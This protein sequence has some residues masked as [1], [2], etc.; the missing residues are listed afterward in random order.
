MSNDFYGDSTRWFIGRV[1]DNV[2]PDKRGRLQIRVYGLH[3]DNQID[4]PNAILPWAETLLP[5]TEGGASGIGKIPQIQ[6]SAMVFG[7]F[8][9]GTTSQSPLILGSLNQNESP[10]STQ[11]IQAGSRGDGAYYTSQSIGSNGTITTP[12]IRSKYQGGNANIDQRRV[13]CMNFFADNGFNPIIAAGIVGNLE[14]E[15]SNFDPT[16]VSGSRGEK[17]QGLAQWN[18]AVG[19]LQQLQRFAARQNKDYLDFFTQLEYI[20]HQLRGKSI[21]NDGGGD[22]SSLYSKLQKCTTFEGGVSDVNS[23]W[24]F[25]K[26]YEVPEDMRTELITREKHARKAYEQWSTTVAS[27]QATSGPQ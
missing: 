26:I 6:P 21:N 17:S 12:D 2:D 24:L 19:R 11:R 3:A 20:V 8:L 18:P 9:D 13:I 16:K 14:G 15:N 5:S 1:V 25:I 23:A 4:I 22:Y 27:A 7:I 10:S